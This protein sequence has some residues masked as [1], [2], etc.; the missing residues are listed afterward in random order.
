MDQH[1]AEIAGVAHELEDAAEPLGLVRLEAAD[2]EAGAAGH[3]ARAGDDGEVADAADEGELRGVE[4]FAAHVVAPAL[5]VPAERGL[6][7]RRRGCRARRRP[8]RVGPTVCS[9]LQAVLASAS[10]PRLTRSPVTAT[11]SGACSRMCWT[12]L[13]RPSPASDVVPAQAPVE[14]AG[15]PLVDQFGPADRRQRRQVNVRNMGEG[16]HCG[17]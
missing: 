17:G 14:V 15:D 9:Q 2:G 1:D 13:C 7:H 12:R 5:A 16:D 11:K 8:R 3:G 4:R 6:R 10:S